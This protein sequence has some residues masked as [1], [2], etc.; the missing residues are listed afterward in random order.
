MLQ[1]EAWHGVFSLDDGQAA[2]ALRNAMP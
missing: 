2:W 1:R